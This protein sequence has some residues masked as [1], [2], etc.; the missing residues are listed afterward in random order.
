MKNMN[1]KKTADNEFI[2]ASADF[3]RARNRA[4]ISKIHNIMNSQKD[5][6]LS[7]YDVREI[8]KPKNQ[9][10]L[11][12]KTVPLKLIMGSEGRYRDFNRDFQ[13][14]SEY[15]RTRWESVDR[16][17]LKDKP[18]PA[19]QLYEIGGAYFVRDGNHRVSVARSGGVEEI[20]AEVVSLSSEIT[21]KPA[22]TNDDLRRAVIDLEKKIFYEKTDFLKLTG[23]NGLVF[24]TTGR[25]DKIYEHILDHKYFLNMEKNEEIP[26]Q[27]AMVSWYNDYYKPLIKIITGEK[28]CDRFPGQCPADLY[29]WIIRHW[30][31]LKR[32]HGDEYPMHKAAKNFSSRYGNRKKAVKKPRFFG[33]IFGYE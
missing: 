11:G 5:D 30:D 29:I 26:F 17:H 6:L 20:D 21:I 23:D 13:P 14:R 28:I 31:F 16:A 18:L 1:E 8:L 12:M 32:K 4:F 7:F 10:Y 9:V 15:M 19:I 2:Q 24:T 33:R 22:M 27:D 3:N 25:Y